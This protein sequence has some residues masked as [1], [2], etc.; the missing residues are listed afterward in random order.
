MPSRLAYELL[1]RRRPTWDIGPRAE[2]VELVNSGRL[3]PDTLPPGRAVDLGCGT[4]ANALFLAEHGFDV[5]GIDF[6]PTALR[7]ARD[8]AAKSAMGDRARFVLGDLTGEAISGAEGPFDLLV[9]YGTLED[10]WASK[11]PA[12]SDTVKRLSH[13]GSVFVCWC[14]Y[15][16]RKDLPWLSLSRPSRMFPLTLLRG[17]EEELFGDSFDIMSYPVREPRP[18][19]K[20]GAACF[21]MTKR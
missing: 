14:F 11:R 3:T 13:S 19:P 10:F 16:A 8:E 9:S 18:A 15:A 7:K 21:V 20:A 17:E 5:V 12:V 4:G 1:Y 6:S 2:L